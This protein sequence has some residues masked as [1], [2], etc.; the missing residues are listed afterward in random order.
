MIISQDSPEF[1]EFQNI[2]RKFFALRNGVVAD[3][4]KK[5]DCP[6]SIIFGLTMPEMMQVAA[7]TRHSAGLARQLWANDT[8]RES[9]LLATMIWPVEDLSIDEAR[10]LVNG[11]PSIEI[12]DSLCHKLLRKTPYAFDLVGEFAD[13]RR[14][15]SRYVAVRL[16]FN[17]LGND[18][19]RAEKTARMFLSDTFRPVASVARTLLSEIEFL[20]GDGDF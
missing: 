14:G 19:D 6:Q 16:A 11:V 7:S 12:A 1:S 4:L 3:S 20:K 2:K 18:M 15:L 17:L 8:T 10:E 5:A 9:M 13:D